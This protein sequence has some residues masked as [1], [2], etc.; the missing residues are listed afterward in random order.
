M[1]VHSPHPSLTRER[2]NDCQWGTENHWD[3]LRYFINSSI[4][5]CNPSTLKRPCVKWGNK[6]LKGFFREMFPEFWTHGGSHD[7]Y[8]TWWSCCKGIGIYA[9]GHFTGRTWL[10]S[11]GG[12]LVLG[13]LF[14]GN[15]SSLGSEV[16]TFKN[17]Q[18][19]IA[20]A[21]HRC[22]DVRILCIFFC[23]TLAAL[24]QMNVDYFEETFYA[25][26][27]RELDIIFQVMQN[28]VE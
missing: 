8:R 12:C 11:I 4:Q 20:D 5:E 6:Y 14:F 9:S 24:I 17:L 7:Y 19:K 26:V 21:S 23:Y 28:L 25:F 16:P 15:P 2:C 18:A 27:F 22:L 13:K 3:H 10:H 1:F